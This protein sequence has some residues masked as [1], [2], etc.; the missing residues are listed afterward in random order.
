LA[1][2]S[3]AISKKG[4]SV[5]EHLS[6]LKGRPFL[7]TRGNALGYV[8]EVLVCDHALMAASFDGSIDH[9]L[10]EERPEQKELRNHLGLMLLSRFTRRQAVYLEDTRPDKAASNL[11]SER[12]SLLMWLVPALGSQA[13]NQIA[14]SLRSTKIVRTNELIVKSVLELEDQMIESEPKPQ[15][16]LFVED[17]GILYVHTSLGDQIWIP[18]FRA[19][20]ESL[21]AGEQIGDV[22]L[23]AGCAAQILAASDE[24]SARQLLEQLGYY[25]PA[26]V[27]TQPIDYGDIEDLGEL[28]QSP[29]AL[30]GV[31]ENEELASIS[32]GEDIE[33]AD[34]PDDID[35][36][37]GKSQGPEDRKTSLDGEPSPRRNASD[38]HIRADQKEHEGGE[39]SGS[40]N[41]AV[42]P[43]NTKETTSHSGKDEGR[44]K[45]ENSEPKER[46]SS[47]RTQR[48][49][50]YVLPKGDERSAGGQKGSNKEL[51]DEIDTAATASVV[52]WESKRGFDPRVQ[53][54]NNPGFDIISKPKD[55]GVT[56][57]I[58]V[59]GLADSWTERGVKLSRTQ[60]Q[61]AREKGDDFWLYVVEHALDPKKRNV[62]AI[63]NP[64]DKSDEF[65]FD[66]GWI[67]IAE[68]KS[69]DQRML[70]EVG[71]H[72]EVKNWG[73]GE[74][75][76]VDRR[77]VGIQL[78]IKFMLAT[79][80]LTY[81]S[82]TF[83]LLED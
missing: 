5:F 43:T 76:K 67:D 77:G 23:L 50:S 35:E 52:D 41:G 1:K 65:W 28:S 40:S 16:A 46:K 55:G 60:M 9:L 14:T 73:K 26:W 3:D 63:R 42:Q 82:E 19:V 47:L 38:Q 37:Q 56:R 75:L 71:R 32:H 57:Y 29:H 54:H 59:K 10:I 48:L 33:I 62:H 79:K 39:R 22:R 30:D 58:E 21:A 44:S 31:Q 45:S 74:I 49:R 53:P 25:E 18:A 2:I 4:D 24:I 36:P 20:F 34:A 68:E 78:T 61:F 8:D 17:D 15:D 51:I 72:I 6:K 12:S 66:Q 69:G 70:L 7:P 83:Q 11:L 81:N 13:A 80:L 64:F 27:G